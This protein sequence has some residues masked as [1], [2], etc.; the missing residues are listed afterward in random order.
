MKLVDQQV[1]PSPGQVRRQAFGF[2]T[3]DLSRSQPQFHEV[4]N[5]PLG[6]DHPQLGRGMA[7]QQQNVPEQRP[8]LRRIMC[9]RQIAQLAQELEKLRLP[10]KL[11]NQVGEALFLAALVGAGFAWRKPLVLVG[12]NAPGVFLRQQELTDAGPLLCGRQLI[13]PSNAA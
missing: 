6:E 8:L 12:L 11:R 9:R 2:M 5:V 10:G 4:H 7:Q 13:E 1:R 3:Q